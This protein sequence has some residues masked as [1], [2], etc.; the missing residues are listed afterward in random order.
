VLV[1]LAW[2]VISGDYSY[3]V[4]FEESKGTSGKLLPGIRDDISLTAMTDFKP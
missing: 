4:D 3:D 1:L 2:A